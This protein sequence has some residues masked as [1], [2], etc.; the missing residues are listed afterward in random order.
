M[1]DFQE[2]LKEEAGVVSEDFGGA[3]GNMMNRPMTAGMQRGLNMMNRATAG[4]NDDQ[5]GVKK[6]MSSI[7]KQAETLD[8]KSL[9][10]L[11]MM[12]AQMS[13]QASGDLGHPIEDQAVNPKARYQGGNS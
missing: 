10:K 13:R 6:I 5:M 12:I 2:W 1:R 3:L 8:P 4:M 7:L 9:R 11:S